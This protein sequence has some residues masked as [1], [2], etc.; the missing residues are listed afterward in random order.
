MTVTT[1]EGINLDVRDERASFECAALDGGDS[2][3]S[4]DDGYEVGAS[5]K[6]I[7]FDVRNAGFARNRRLC[8]DL[9]SKILLRGGLGSHSVNSAVAVEGV[10]PNQN[11]NQNMSHVLP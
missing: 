9:T 11:Q 7:G 8:G 10:H 4:E 3:W 6:R 5:Y 2:R 1:L